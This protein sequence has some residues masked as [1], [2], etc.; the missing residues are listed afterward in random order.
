M[1]TYC[2]KAGSPVVEIGVAGSVTNNDLEGWLNH[3]R[4]DLEQNGKSR[5]LEVIEQFRGIEPA[6]IWTDI[7]LGMSLARKV[8]RVA[9]VADKG[10]IR[11]LSKLGGV[12]TRG[13]EVR[14]FAP[15]ELD[16]ARA[17]VGAR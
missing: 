11:A 12:F 14:S 17:W 10:W 8:D 4:V 6:A 3:L 9:V 7:K 16:E 15:A 5:I 1:I 13:A 2:T